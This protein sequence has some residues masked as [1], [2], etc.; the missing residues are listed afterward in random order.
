[1]LS[2]C[3]E[4]MF[5]HPIVVLDKFTSGEVEFVEFATC[6]TCGKRPV[7]D[8]DAR[9]RRRLRL[10]GRP[11]D[12]A[13]DGTLPLEYAPNSPEFPKK[14]ELQYVRVDRLYT[15]EFCNLKTWTTSCKK[16]ITLN[17]KA[18]QILMDRDGYSNASDAY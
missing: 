14:C 6:T 15:I 9:T 8:L 2:D 1:M 12:A 13:H 7:A 11:G 16:P 5:N 17:G 18:V 10:V 3:N 4:K